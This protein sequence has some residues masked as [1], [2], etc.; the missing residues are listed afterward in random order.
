MSA[1]PV[2]VFDLDGTLFD[3][4]PDLLRAL[5]QVLAEIGRPA[6]DQNQVSTLYGHGAGALLRRAFKLAGAD[7][8]NDRL[9]GL[10]ER[11]VGLY[12]ADIAR[13]TR[14]YPGL[15]AAL[16]R[17]VARGAALAVCTNKREVLARALLAETGFA[18]Y[19]SAVIGGDSLPEAKPCPEP[20]IA[21]VERSGGQPASAV[22]VG[23]SATDVATARAAGIPAIAVDFGFCDV[24]AGE[25]GAD[26]VIS[27]YDALD[28]ALAAVHPAFNRAG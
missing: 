19:F 21:A 1:I 5:N 23:D 22:M 27:H 26:A 15:A 2:V 25:L 10:V 11:F 8:E 28:A 13:S 18:E 12:A 6:V 9:P 24:P 16:D 20:L 14:P 7:I 3:T 17:L 4:G